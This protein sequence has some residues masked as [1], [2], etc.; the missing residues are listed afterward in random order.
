MCV[1]LYFVL[2]FILY[3]ADQACGRVRQQH[4]ALVLRCVTIVCGYNNMDS[5][6]AN[7]LGGP[8]NREVGHLWSNFRDCL[9]IGPT[10]DESTDLNT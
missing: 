2:C 3:A 6:W 4:V 9:G 5:I 8:S 10:T 1:V 7:R